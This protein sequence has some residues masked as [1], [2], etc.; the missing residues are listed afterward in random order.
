MINN[1]MRGRPPLPFRGNKSINKEQLI[2]IL[3]SPL[4]NDDNIIYVDLFGGSF[5]I[6]YLIHKLHPNNRVICNDY[7]KYI[8][9][10]QNIP[11]TNAILK[12]CRKLL[13]REYK[14]KERFDTIDEYAIKQ[15]IQQQLVYGY[16]DYQTISSRLCYSGTN[17]ITSVNDILKNKLYNRLSNEINPNY[18]DY[19]EG[20]EFRSCDWKIL[21][22]EF[23]QLND[24][25]IL[26][27]ADPPY[28]N[29]DMSG[30]NNNDWKLEDALNVLTIMENKYYIL[31][32]STKS[33][34]T[35]IINYAS[36]YT[37]ILRDY[38]ISYI[39]RGNVNKDNIINYDVMIYKL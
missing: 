34:I 20:I 32:T 36:K 28:L 33:G 2:N 9:R 7:D 16:I 25:K 21:Y 13:S 12:Q 37:P 14:P 15:Y 10:L 27:I 35:E 26:F 30:Y 11:K 17:N 19:I 8:V 39:N 18:D 29:T 23:M 24:S 6:S 4:L 3:S 31:F 5:Y 22:D 38:N 1:H